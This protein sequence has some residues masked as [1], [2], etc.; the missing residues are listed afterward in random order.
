MPQLGLDDFEIDLD[1]FTLTH[2]CV[3]IPFGTKPLDLLVYRIEQKH[4]VGSVRSFARHRDLLTTSSANTKGASP[5]Q[6]ARPNRRRSGSRMPD[7]CT[8]PLIFWLRKIGVGWRRRKHEDK[9][10]P[11]RER[12]E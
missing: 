11:T 4:Q 8:Q 5:Y 3:E 7:R 6:G 2:A 10:P 12:L 9:S 1:L